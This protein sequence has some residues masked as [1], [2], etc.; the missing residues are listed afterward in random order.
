MLSIWDT[1]QTCLILH[2]FYFFQISFSTDKLFLVTGLIE[3]VFYHYSDSELLFLAKFQKPLRQILYPCLK[4]CTP[5]GKKP[6][7]G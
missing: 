4:P 7:Y 2:K 3:A 5:A 1:Q 6:A